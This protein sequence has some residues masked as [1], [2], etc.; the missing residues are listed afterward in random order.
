MRTA[1]ISDIS[2]NGKK[3]GFPKTGTLHLPYVP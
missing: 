3:F 2:T 1:K